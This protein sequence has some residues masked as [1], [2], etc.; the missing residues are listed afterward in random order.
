MQVGLAALSKG[1]QVPQLGQVVCRP[2]RDA[3]WA[4]RKG[5]R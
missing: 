1:R 3:R 2:D 4:V 5:E